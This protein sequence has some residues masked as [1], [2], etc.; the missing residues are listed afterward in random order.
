[1]RRLALLLLAVLCLPL[2]AADVPV[3][4]TQD[5]TVAGWPVLHQG[6]VKP[7]SVAAEE[8]LLG[9]AG[10]A[11]FGLVSSPGRLLER[12]VPPTDQLMAMLLAPQAWQDTPLIHVPW[13]PL[14]KALKIDGQWASLRECEAGQGAWV[15]AVQRKQAADRTG[16]KIPWSRDDQAAWELALRIDLAQ[17]VLRGRTLLLTPLAVDG[18]ER[19]QALALLKP[20]DDGGGRPWRSRW[21]AEVANKGDKADDALRKSDLWLSFEDLIRDPDPL[22]AA[23][24]ATSS[25]GK[26]RDQIKDLGP[27]L[28]TGGEGP[29]YVLPGVQDLARARGE[30]HN[31][32]YATANVAGWPGNAVLAIEQAY[33]RSR[34]FTWAWLGL[35]LGGLVTALGLARQ[36]RN[37]GTGGLART[38]G[39]TLSVLGL[40]ACVVGLAARTTITGMGAV[41]NLYETLVFV[42]LLTGVLGLILARTTGNPLVAV[43][44]GIVA[45]LCAMVGEAMP[46]EMGAQIPQLQPVL[47]SRFWLWIHVKVVVASYAAFALALGLGNWTLW[48]AWREGRDVTADEARPLY[49]CLQVGTVLIIAGTLLGAWW[50]DEAWG[51]FWGWDPKEIGALIVALTY[52]IPL[53]LRYVGAVSPTGLAGWSVLGFL[54]VLW[55]WYGV[56]F[57]LGAGLHAYGFGSG[58]Q[59]LVLPIAGLQIVLTAWQL[60]SIRRTRIRSA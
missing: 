16:E 30:A 9:I 48:K 29:T 22:L 50:A 45:G 41:T 17:E 4:P 14:Q 56:N 21:L 46:P 1:M 47:R 23:L 15:P 39:T 53:H 51:R 28:A 26:F 55:S 6:R 59:H 3:I 36:R 52:L 27:A 20:A 13:L 34:I 19:A 35:L 5:A 54:A 33:H 10:K 44:G 43:A 7:F 57:L 37:P 49:R 38:L 42:A 2:T 8:T 40:L 31:R 25:L 32:E 12:R 18:P 11:P 24:P 58:G 60:R